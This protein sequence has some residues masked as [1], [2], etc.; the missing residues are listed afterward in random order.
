MEGWPAEALERKY[1]KQEQRI[2][3]LDAADASMDLGGGS[4]NDKDAV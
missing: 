2:H 1:Q 4:G 3:E